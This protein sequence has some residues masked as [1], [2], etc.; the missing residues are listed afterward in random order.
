MH[1][2]VGIWFLL[3]CCV[4]S[5]F[6]VFVVVV[7]I[8]IIAV[9]VCHSRR[10]CLKMVEPIDY[11]HWIWIRF[12][13]LCVPLKWK[14]TAILLDFSTF[15]NWMLVY[16]L[17]ENPLSFYNCLVTEQYVHQMVEIEQIKDIYL[18]RIVSRQT[19]VASRSIMIAANSRKTFLSNYSVVKPENC[20]AKITERSKMIQLKFSGKKDAAPCT[21]KRC[22]KECEHEK[23]NR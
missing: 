10:C 9:A 8:V 2:L 17:E 1:T 3:I 14:L 6:F 18:I 13:A 19:P 4:L 5:F 11:W 16:F 22:K 12:F 7:L 21:H 23:K 20:L 15:S